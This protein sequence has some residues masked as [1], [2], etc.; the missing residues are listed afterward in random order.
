MDK[1]KFL[2]LETLMHISR[3]AIPITSWSSRHATWL[4]LYEISPN[5]STKLN[6]L[7]YRYAFMQIL[8]YFTIGRCGGPGGPFG[9]GLGPFCRGFHWF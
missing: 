9:I 7:I 4:K 5:M 1:Q 2:T 6:N 8:Q 3:W